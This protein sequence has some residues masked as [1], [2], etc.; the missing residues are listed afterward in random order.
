MDIILFICWALFFFIPFDI[1]SN[2]NVDVF[3]KQE[4][5]LFVYMKKKLA[6]WNLFI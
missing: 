3:V 1:W 4:F 2:M 5:I 6:I